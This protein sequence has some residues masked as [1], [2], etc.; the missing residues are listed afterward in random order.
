[1]Y[2]LIARYWHDENDSDRDDEDEI[3]HEDVHIHHRE[4]L[5]SLKTLQYLAFPLLLV[6]AVGSYKIIEKSYEY[7]TLDISAVEAKKIAHEYLV[8]KNISLDRFKPL[9]LIAEKSE[10]A[11]QYVRY[12]LADKAN[13]LKKEYQ[14]NGLNQKTIAFDK[15]P[16]YGIRFAQFDTGSIEER[17]REYAVAVEGNGTVRRVMSM[18][19]ESEKINSLTEEEARNFI[20]S[21]LKSLNITPAIDTFK[22]I[23]AVMTKLPNRHDWTFTFEHEYSPEVKPRVIVKL[24]GDTLSDIETTYFA[25]ETYLR[26][27]EKDKAIL[28]LVQAFSAIVLIV[29][30]LSLYLYQ[31][32]RITGW[33]LI[34]QIIIGAIAVLIIGSS[35]NKLPVLMASFNTTNPWQSQ[36]LSS[37]TRI[38]ISLIMSVLPIAALL[39]IIEQRYQ[40]KIKA[41]NLKQASIIAGY[42]IFLYA[43]FG[44]LLALGGL[45]YIV[46]PPHIQDGAAYIPGASYL[47][48]TISQAILELLLVAGIIS[49]LSKIHVHRWVSVAAVSILTATLIYP[50]DY[51]PFVWWYLLLYIGVIALGFYIILDWVLI[52]HPDLITGIVLVPFILEGLRMIAHPPYNGIIPFA[53][54]TILIFVLIVGFI[55][56]NKKE[57]KTR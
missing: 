39:F 46:W 20:I 25:P 47:F 7:D 14:L 12:V 19:P 41:L 24:A 31:P 8:S 22:E 57:M 34:A 37:V 38:L 27:V 15:P 30:L 45:R 3:V 13:D 49:I 26:L 51:T 44:V 9:M 52:D 16:R 17:A 2:A 50:I 36:V 40:L 53:G 42:G 32:V 18:L 6:G 1:M 4:P 23:S 11:Q 48:R 56:L 54:I 33:S 43:F 10:P 28:Q 21:H 55:Q 5:M 35:F 29:I